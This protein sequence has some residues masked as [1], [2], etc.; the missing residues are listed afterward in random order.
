MDDKDKTEAQLINELTEL[1]QRIAEL[2]ESKIELKQAEEMLQKKENKYRTLL[3]NLPQ[4][5]FHKD[6]NSV[7]V[8]CNENYARDLKI[9]PVEIVGKTDYDFYP[10]E[11]A[12]KYRADD[13]RVLT[14]GTTMDIVEKYINDGRE[15]IVQTVKTA[16]KDERGTI[17]GLLG[18]FWDITE[19]K[20]ME[21]MLEK[22][23]EQ[24]RNFLENLN[25]I[26]YET[27][28][29][30]N[31][32][33]TNKMTEIVTGVALK[34]IIGN[35]FL[36]LFTKESQEVA[37]DVYQRTLNGESPEYELT[38]TNGRICRF[39]NKP[40]RDKNGTIIGVFGIARDITERKHAEEALKKSEERYYN[41]IEHANDGIFYVNEE[42]V[43][44]IFNKKAEDI[45]GY[46][47]EEVQGKSIALLT[48]PSEREF[49]RK[50]LDEFKKN[51]TLDIV[52]KSMEGIGLSKDGQEL[53]V[54]YS[55]STIDLHGGHVIIGIVRDITERKKR[56]REIKETRDFLENVF[57][58][59]VDGIITSDSR[60]FITSVN[61]ATEK[62]FGYSENE[63]LGKHTSELAPKGTKH[64]ERT[65][66]IGTM[67]KK[68]GFVTGIDFPWLRKDGS[69]VD[70]EM[71]VTLLKDKKG[72][73]T[74]A[75]GV[76]R[77]ITERKK[78]EREIK[79]GKEFLENIFSTSADGI[80]VGDSEGYITMVN[81]ATGKML[82]YSKD[83][84]IGRHPIDF[85][86]KDK[87]HKD[88]G[89][90]VIEEVMRKVVMTGIERTWIRKDGSL[91]DIEINL[92]F[93]KDSSGNITGSI[94]GLRDIT[95]RKQTDEAL[96]RV[97]E[98]L[99]S[100]GP[101]ADSNIKK[102][103]AT[104]GLVL[105]GVCALYNKEEGP[106]LCTIEGWNIPKDF[107]RKDRKKGHICN[108]VIRVHNDD[109]FVVNDLGKSP[110]AKTDSN[111]NKYKLKAYVGCAVK[112]GDKTIGSL[113]VVYKENKTF[114]SNELNI[115][116]ILAKAL[117]V[118]EER[119]KALDELKHHQQMLE[120]SERNIKE[121]S[122]KILSV[123]EEEGKKLSLGLHDEVGSMTVA[124]SANLSIAEEEVK[125]NNVKAAL[126]RINH[127]R[128]VLQE[129]VEKL[130]KM[131]TDLRPPNLDIVGL[132]S[133]L[134]DYFSTL[135][136]QTKIKIGFSVSMD[137]KKIDDDIAIVLYRVTQEALNNI[138][139]HARAKRV[140]I[141]LY[142][143]KNNI[144]LTIRDDGNGFDVE[145]RLQKTKG[146][147]LRG[148]RERVES[149][150][151][152]FAIKSASKQGTEISATIPQEEYTL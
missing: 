43:I 131:S 134:R 60:G 51:K 53:P 46:S 126:N 37:T 72:N 106:L 133:V 111:I 137:D 4:K 73:T 146:L 70:I 67:I 128:N 5:I 148:M 101:D 80:L 129:S 22:S 109:P 85:A 78:S 16:V 118:E 55:L 65:K 39:K 105:K 114:N 95:E 88:S 15:E 147:G 120:V 123:R 9:N 18:I 47:R 63:F 29:S 76:L 125:D 99:L 42:G 17:V 21:E 103:I 77:D 54:E 64:E 94:A 124:L 48:A 104:A 87:K 90:K 122:R 97:N 49:Q 40:R 62:M 138:V 69:Q 59:S 2:E 31:V 112:I 149:L 57:R 142:F 52:E 23:E 144:T 27:D 24:F 74:G 145:K 121:F 6:R 14:S 115:L 117:A 1:R 26:A 50:S 61:E 35:P 92:A 10:K 12:E 127:T 96:K 7:Y 79:E 116:S 136:K 32:T 108:D 83:E 91:I 44:I 71:N 140:K 25:D 86:K 130:K 11:L 75:T 89:K 33:Y 150:G 38:F 151:G 58:T 113:C 45:F 41:L 152:T 102:I 100:F 110:Y 28:S 20:R 19:K 141:R 13:K 139:R 107:K 8:S 143:Q 56:E 84:L 93:L 135:K 98:C 119:K 34:D 36:P 3:E 81:E 68:Q 132:P 30:G 66:E 82:G